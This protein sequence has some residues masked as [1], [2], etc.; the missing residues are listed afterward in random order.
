MIEKFSLGSE[1]SVLLKLL[2]LAYK[3][4]GQSWGVGRLGSQ[5][6]GDR[7]GEEGGRGGARLD[8]GPETRGW[9]WLGEEEQER[10]VSD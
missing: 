10:A 3:Q 1:M 9:C 2:P 5:I 7:A 6:Q 4:G 8:V